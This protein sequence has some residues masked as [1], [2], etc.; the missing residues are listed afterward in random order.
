[1]QFARH[2]DPALECYAVDKAR[3]LGRQALEDG[4]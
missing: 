2:Q 4:Q 1:M 3:F